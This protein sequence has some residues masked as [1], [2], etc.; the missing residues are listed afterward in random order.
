MRVVTTARL[1][2]QPL[3]VRESQVLPEPGPSPSCSLRTSQSSRPCRPCSE[4][5]ESPSAL[6]AH[7]AQQGGGREMGGQLCRALC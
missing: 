3:L 1:S 5:E 4:D 7:S 6:E 2:E